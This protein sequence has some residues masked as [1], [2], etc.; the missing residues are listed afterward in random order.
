MPIGV[1]VAVAIVCVVVAV[2]TSAQRADEVSFNREQQLIRQ[3]IADDGERTLHL[4][5]STAAAPRA[6]L[7]IRDSYDPQWVERR[8]GKWLE[9]FSHDD[10]VVIV[11]GADQIKYASSQAAIDVR[12]IDLAAELAPTLDLLRGRLS[13][14]PSHT[15]AVIAGQVAEKPGRST[16][17]IQRFHRQARDRRRGGGRLR[18]R[19]RAR[20]RPRADRVRRQIHYRSTAAGNRRAPATDR[21]AQDRRRRA[22]RRRPASPNSPIPEATSIARFAWKPTTPGGADRGE[23][24]AV[25][26]PWRSPAS[27]CWWA[28]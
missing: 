27:R 28:W 22:G 5:E 14:V 13:A 24:G 9:S 17:L 6:T 7:K 19:S 25:H 15:I 12:S 1:I 11:D 18:R 4:A 23:R 2:L 20:Q 10:V 16:A 8:V 3:A 26:H 21:P